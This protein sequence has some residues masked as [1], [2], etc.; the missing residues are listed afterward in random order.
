MQKYD[1]F[2]TRTNFL[3]L[4]F[5][6]IVPTTVIRYIITLKSSLSMDGM[7]GSGNSFPEK[8]GDRTDYR[9]CS[10]T[11]PVVM[12]RKKRPVLMPLRPTTC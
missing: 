8:N 6:H 1:K 9:K 3:F 2:L 10:V 12:Q 4:F 11:R 5:F 7:I